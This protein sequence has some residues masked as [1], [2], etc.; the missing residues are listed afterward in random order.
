[1]ATKKKD[2]GHELTDAELAAL[3]KRVGNEFKIALMNVQKR[4]R[5]YMQQFQ[6]ED[7]EKRQM[8]KAGTL[9]KAEYQQWRMNKMFVGQRWE[10]MKDTLAADMANAQKIARH[11]AGEAVKDVYAL[12]YN[13]GTYEVEKG[14]KIN[15]SFTLYDHAS[16]ERLLRDKPDLLPQPGKKTAQAIAEGKA[17]RWSKAKLQSIATQAVLQGGTVPQMAKW[18]AGNLGET[19]RKAA[20]RAARTM[21]TEAESAGRVESYK[22]AESLGIQM[23]QVWISAIDNRTR[24]THRLLNGQRRKVGK[25]FEVEGKQIMY[26]GDPDA[27]PSMVYNCRCTL[28]AAVAGTKL[29]AQLDG[30]WKDVNLGGMTY[31]QWK[32]QTDETPSAIK[33]KMAQIQ[34]EMDLV[35]DTPY[36]GI[37]KTPVTLQDYE[38]KKDSIDAK[39]AYYNQQIDKICAAGTFTAQE[40]A[41]MDKFQQ[42]IDLCYQYKADGD[43][44]LSHKKEIQELQA[45]LDAFGAPDKKP[46][47]QGPFGADAY[48]QARIDAALN[49]TSRYDADKTWR[50]DLDKIWDNLSEF[51]QYSIWEYTHNSNPIN[52]PLSGYEQSW[53]RGSF[54]GLG[55]TDW[56]SED[57]WR[58][59]NTREFARKFGTDNHVDYYNT[60]TALTKAIEKSPLEH[61]AWFVRGSDSSGLAG[62]LEGNLVSFDDAKALLDGGKISDL[63]QLCVGQT[64]QTHAFMSTGIATDA[65]FTG[66]VAYRIYAPAGTHAIYAEPTSYFG[67]TISGETLYTK[68][69]DYY[70]VGGEAEMIFQRGTEFRIRDIKYDQW[71]GKYIVDMEVVGQPDYFKSGSEETYDGGATAHTRRH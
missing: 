1:M 68:R 29:D 37:W 52:K 56:G 55:N 14:S 71:E 60:I 27:D 31:E 7:K 40:Q 43:M 28:I 6:A 57:A 70:S 45:K 8:V 16:V 22:R 53:D 35:K 42:M 23:E 36:T 10:A 41:Q 12:N 47:T 65:G 64:F 61:D 20:V 30:M 5:E 49:F 15:T 26:P 63:Q 21:I 3:E 48:S 4:L 51:E 67:D 39:V 44:Y 59:F 69:Q 33:G 46:A 32:Y 9:T 24:H 2:K 19:N 34:A 62:L 66:N 58:R 25:P 17:K 54:L 11:M 18:I 38:A 13:Y 50:A